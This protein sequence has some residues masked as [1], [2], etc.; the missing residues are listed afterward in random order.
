MSERCAATYYDGV[1]GRAH[2]VELR[3]VGTSHY[4]IE[5]DGVVRGGALSALVMTP[6]LARV[7]RT[8]ELPDGARVLVA[9][10]APIESWFPQRNRFEA[11]VDRLERHA[12]VVGAAM[13]VCVA[14]L[15]IGAIWGVPSAADAIARKIP[16]GVEES[17]GAEVLG[18]LDRMGLKPST[19][20]AGRREAL[21]ER[22]EKLAADSGAHYVLAFRDAPSVGANAFAIPGG[23]VVVTDQLVRKLGDDRE[24]DAVVAHE[25]G[26]QQRR[27]ALRQTLRGSM[28]AIV[29]AFF[30]GDVSS[31]GAVVVAVPTFL[32]TS[33]Y[34]REFEDEA[35]RYA[36]DLLAQHGESPHWFAEAMRVLQAARAS[37]TRSH[38][39]Y[40][41]SHPDT[42]DRIGEAEAAAAR[43]AA[44]HPDLCPAGVCPGE[45]PD[46]DSVCEDCDDDD[47]ED[48]SDTSSSNLSC[49]KD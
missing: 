49:N 6:P 25:I 27:H 48:E 30:A 47:D 5:G 22:F 17:L 32:L 7:A 37:R 3:R 1:S 31:A 33:H 20:D 43:F 29:A 21:D 4:A 10:D 35:D 41:S 18:S 26:H 19:L 13:F 12:Y 9:H 2:A 11:F 46:D 34:S 45:E 14:T 24:F 15:A 44:A 36:F 16:P 8:I 42:A 28:V 39:A 40:L 38:L 23:T